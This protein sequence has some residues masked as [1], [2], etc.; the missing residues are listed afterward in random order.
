MNHILTSKH[1]PSI[2]KKK[3][4]VVPE[5]ADYSGWK[6]AKHRMYPED[7]ISESQGVR[8]NDGDINTLERTVCIPLKR[9][10]TYLHGGSET[11]NV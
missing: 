3:A 10:N 11:L 9:E 7:L 2:K 4:K 8:K 1:Y 5:E 6:Q